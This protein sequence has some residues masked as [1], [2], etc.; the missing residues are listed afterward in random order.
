M[1]LCYDTLI[2]IGELEEDFALP[3]KVTNDNNP[4]GTH[5]IW[6]ITEALKDPK[7]PFEDEIERLRLEIVEKF[8]KSVIS[9][10]LPTT[11]M[12]GD[13]MHIALVGNAV[14]FRTTRVRAI[15]HAWEDEAKRLCDDLE[16]KGIITKVT[17]ATDWVAPGHFV[18]K[19]G[20]S[21]DNI[22]IRL[23]TDFRMLNKYILVHS[24]RLLIFSAILPG[25]SLCVWQGHYA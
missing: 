18:A 15:P 12:K 16:Q 19:K 11:P 20:C 17:E 3:K 8:H 5:Q 13:P 24:A 7:G 23:V 25:C 10:E 9:D 1:L 22:K 14:P 21:P 4:E 2:D 6:G